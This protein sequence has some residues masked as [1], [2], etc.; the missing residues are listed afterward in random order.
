MEHKSRVIQ[1][2]IQRIIQLDLSGKKRTRC[3]FQRFALALLST[4]ISG[5]T[6]QLGTA[7]IYHSC[8][9]KPTL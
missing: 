4:W 2:V 6:A 3:V 8:T 9:F 7:E 1:R 5:K